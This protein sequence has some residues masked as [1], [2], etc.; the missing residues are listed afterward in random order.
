MN[1]LFEFY[2]D[3]FVKLYL[4]LQ[5]LSTNYMTVKTNIVSH[6]LMNL[7]QVIKSDNIQV[8]CTYLY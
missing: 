2:V 1:E 6:S 3:L 8:N 7:K 5:V 4:I